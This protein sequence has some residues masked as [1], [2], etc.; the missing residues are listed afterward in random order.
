MNPNIGLSCEQVDLQSK[1]DIAVE[2]LSNQLYELVDQFYFFDNYQ[3]FKD[4][5]LCLQL[6]GI[7]VVYHS[8][9]KIVG[10]TRLIRRILT[11]NNLE[12]AV[13]YGGSYHHPM[14]QI[15]GHASRI[16]L[17]DALRY[18]LFQ[19]HQQLVYFANINNPE[20]YAYIREMMGM[21]DFKKDGRGNGLVKHLMKQLC[22]IHDWQFD[23]SNPQLVKGLV[24]L[25]PIWSQYHLKDRDEFLQLNPGY[26]SGDSFFAYLS[27]DMMTLGKFIHRSL[28]ESSIVSSASE[29]AESSF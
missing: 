14:L 29:H 20:R 28:S 24:P 22:Q 8:N 3:S 10:F 11:V 18:K 1:S 4:R 13:N 21:S 26:L 5:I 6:P 27:L 2:R 9:E 23:P 12:Y 17:M 25:K 19:P 15:N 7:L 16:C